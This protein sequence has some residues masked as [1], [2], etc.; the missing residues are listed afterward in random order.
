MTLQ[1]L[2]HE[3]EREA[4]LMQGNGKELKVYSSVRDRTAFDLA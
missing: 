3:Y 1:G 2:V 4:P